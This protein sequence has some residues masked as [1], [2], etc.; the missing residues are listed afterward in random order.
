[1]SWK[2]RLSKKDHRFV[3]L[4]T[5]TTV[6]EDLAPEIESRPA[7]WESTVSTEKG[8]AEEEDPGEALPAGD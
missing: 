5:C 7:S 4:L 1:M 2:H 8:G 3:I 6:I